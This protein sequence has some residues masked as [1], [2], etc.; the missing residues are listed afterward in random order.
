MSRFKEFMREKGFY[1]ALL[2]CILAA[3][4]TSVWA[5]RTMVSRM[6]RSD[7]S[8]LQQEETPWQQ[9]EDPAPEL[10]PEPA[11]QPVEQ[12]KNDVPV[13]NG[14]RAQSA[15]P[16]GQAGL[17]E[18]AELQG[19]PEPAAEPSDALVSGYGWPVQGT[20]TQSM[21]GEELVYNP[22]LKDWRTHN[23]T[24]ISCKEGAEVTASMGGKVTALTDSGT[25]GTVVEIT[26]ESGR[27]WRYC[28]LAPQTAVHMDDTVATGQTLGKAGTVEAEE[29]SGV[30]L[31]LEILQEGQYLDPEKLIA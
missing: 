10:A 3:A 22:T 6:S 13:P 14:S 25:F 19:E 9:I 23:G 30:H 20:V 1:F 5:I 7:S 2:G 17:T 26:D 21:S 15:Q 4:L 18:P 31:H 12:K 29:S 27:V 11:T 16:S 28:G 24:D 8:I